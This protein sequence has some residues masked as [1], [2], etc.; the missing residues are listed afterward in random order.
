MQDW[1]VRGQSRA[2]PP[3]GGDAKLSLRPVGECEREHSHYI[4]GASFSRDGLAIAT[5][6]VDGTV[7]LWRPP[8]GKSLQAQSAA[9][10][11]IGESPCILP[12]RACCAEA[13]EEMA[14]S[15]GSDTC[16]AQGCCSRSR[17]CTRRRRAGGERRGWR[18][19][20][21]CPT[22]WGSYCACMRPESGRVLLSGRE[23]RRDT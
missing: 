12:S 9:E 3:R 1:G 14:K 10:E 20:G 22:W 21:A 13:T 11:E 23:E 7:K 19:W 5:S 15:R 2:R 18:V 17:V 8:L 6:S 16:L 4:T